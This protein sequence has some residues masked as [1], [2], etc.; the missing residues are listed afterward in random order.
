VFLDRNPQAYAVFMMCDSQVELQR[1]ISRA[2]DGELDLS[3]DQ[4]KSRTIERNEQF[5]VTI[6]PHKDEC[7]LELRSHEDHELEVVKDNQKIFST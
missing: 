5:E 1:R 6:L 3:Y 2:R 7:D 4:V